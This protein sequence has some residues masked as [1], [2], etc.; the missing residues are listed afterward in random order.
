MQK[1]SKS[2]FH[3]LPKNPKQRNFGAGG[4]KKNGTVM[5]GFNEKQEDRV[6][7]ATNGFRPLSV[8]RERARYLIG[9]IRHGHSA[10]LARMRHFLQ[11]GY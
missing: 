7:T 3:R 11:Q 6:M 10:D 4:T 5:D 1:L 2:G 8:K 9:E